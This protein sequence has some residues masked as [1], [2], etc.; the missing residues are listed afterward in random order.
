MEF[1]DTDK[2]A[3][4][5]ESTGEVWPN[6]LASCASLG[7]S[8]ITHVSVTGPDSPMGPPDRGNAE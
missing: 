3:V 1:P 8:L 7:A 6:F 4:G 2:N 5:N